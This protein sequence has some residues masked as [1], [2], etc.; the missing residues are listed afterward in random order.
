[1]YKNT[2]LAPLLHVK[3]LSVKVGRLLLLAMAQSKLP[4][5]EEVDGY[6]VPELLIPRI[7]SEH[8]YSRGYATGALREAKRML[9]LSNVSGEVVSPSEMIDPA[10]HEM[11]MFTRFY[12]DFSNFI[13]GF[14]HH[15]PTPGIPDG[16]A[17]YERT[18]ALYAK[19]FGVQPDPQYWP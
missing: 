5:L 16:G 4:T 6:P 11:L 3:E 10:W 13:G 9:Y 18:K 17:A 7:E 14:I 12:Q 19:H 8:N 1:L 2:R 15:D